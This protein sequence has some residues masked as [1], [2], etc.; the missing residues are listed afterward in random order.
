MEAA[1]SVGNTAPRYEA[2]S[3]GMGR[4]AQK[5][6]R[7]GGTGV[8]EV[9]RT[10]TTV[11]TDGR[12]ASRVPVLAEYPVPWADDSQTR[13]TR[14]GPGVAP[15]GMSLTSRGTSPP[16]GVHPRPWLILQEARRSVRGHDAQEAP[17]S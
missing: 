10:G 5:A 8:S 3:G 9:T 13:A 2:V 1:A 17:G 11:R 7:R 15:T 14:R 4:R 12:V 6:V 16:R